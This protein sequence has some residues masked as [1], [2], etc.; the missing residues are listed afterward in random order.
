[1][2]L[3]EHYIKEVHSVNDITDKFEEHCGYKPDEPFLEV[4][5]TYNCYGLE[6]RCRKSF[7]KSNWE[8]VKK[9]GYFLS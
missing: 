9:E 7:W 6:K 4:D 5:L 3:L 8:T 1:M 2:N